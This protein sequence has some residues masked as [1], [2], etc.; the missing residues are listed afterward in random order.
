[1]QKTLTIEVK[2]ELKGINRKGNGAGVRYNDKLYF[3][4]HIGKTIP[5]NGISILKSEEDSDYLIVF[6]YE[7]ILYLLLETDNPQEEITK[8]YKLSLSDIYAK[9][10]LGEKVIINLNLPKTEK[11][12]IIKHKIK[13]VKKP[14][15]TPKIKVAPK[16]VNC[17]DIVLIFND[18]QDSNE[19]HKCFE[20][21]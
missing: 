9:Y 20:E 12:P 21:R 11:V 7:N 16:C 6:Y 18:K 3:Y 5:K 8:L 13:K 10:V 19:C 1:M 14:N 15:A 17:G 2:P 4:P